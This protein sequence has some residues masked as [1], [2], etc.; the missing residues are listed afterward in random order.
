MFKRGFYDGNGMKLT[1][2]LKPDWTVNTPAIKT[3]PVQQPPTPTVRQPARPQQARVEPLP[4][5]EYLR[6]LHPTAFFVAGFE[7]EKMLRSPE[8]MK[9]FMSG[10]S[11]GRD[12]QDKLTAALQEI[13]HLWLSFGGPTDG[14]VLMTGKFEKGATAGMLYAKGVM[15]VFL[16]DAHTMMIGPEPSIQAALA[17]LAKAGANDGWV[18][19]R[20]RE[21]ARNHESWIVT[22]YPG[23]DRGINRGD[24]LKQVRRFALGFRLTGDLGMDGEAVADSEEG[25]Q[26]VAAWIDQIKTA[27]RKKTGAGALDSLKITLDGATLRFAAKDDGLLAGDAGRAEMSSE[28]G[29]ELFGLIMG[30]VPGTPRAVAEDKILSVRTGMKRE[31]VLNLL[32]PPL[33]VSGIQGLADSRE[34]WTYQAPFGKRYSV[35]VERGIVSAPP[36]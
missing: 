24:A 5:K 27:A 8:I 10:L 33:S 12:G 28:F 18:T 6:F 4:S 11:E 13:D 22:E 35:R 16:G 3:G 25:A 36:H 23:A 14:V 21:L 1:P 32:G 30:A 31:E 26:K 19:R 7:V 15:P 29:V 9:A 2:L 17:R 34:T 20:A